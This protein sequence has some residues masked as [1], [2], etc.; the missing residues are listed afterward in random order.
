MKKHT[1]LLN[2]PSRVALGILV[3][4]SSTPE[5]VCCVS[6]ERKDHCLLAICWEDFGFLSYSTRIT[7]SHNKFFVLPVLFLSVWHHKSFQEFSR[8][9][10]EK[11]LNSKVLIVA[12]MFLLK[13]Y[14]MSECCHSDTGRFTVSSTG[15]LSSGQQDEKK[16]GWRL[17]K[18]WSSGFSRHQKSQPARERKTWW[19][20]PPP[21]WHCRWNAPGAFLANTSRGRAAGISGWQRRPSSETCDVLSESISASQSPQHEPQCS[22]VAWCAWSALSK[23][24]RDYHFLHG[25]FDFAQM[26]NSASDV[27]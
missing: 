9:L 27:E 23:P 18:P 17:E 14:L 3:F 4:S 15:T 24:G 25:C 1:K 19:V 7:R 6:P 5:V 22:T 20:T 12:E 8:Q 2:L 26:W 11:A 16:P 13:S 10:S 21:S